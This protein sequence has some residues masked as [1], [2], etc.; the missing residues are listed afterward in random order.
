MDFFRK[1]SDQKYKWGMNMVKYMF[2]I[3]VLFV[4]IHAYA[5]PSNLGLSDDLFGKK[6][7]KDIKVTIEETESTEIRT[8]KSK[9]SQSIDVYLGYMPFS[10]DGTFT[11]NSYPGE[12]VYKAKPA[13][14]GAG[15][16]TFLGKYFCNALEIGAFSG[17]YRDNTNPNIKAVDFTTMFICYQPI[18]RY[19]V[20]KQDPELLSLYAG[21]ILGYSHTTFTY[22]IS[23]SNEEITDTG[24]MIGV[25]AGMK[26]KYVFIEFRAY[27]SPGLEIDDGPREI[28]EGFTA[29]TIGLGCS[30]CF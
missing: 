1:L 28:S 23:G 8:D 10:G 4:A 7:F 9:L 18:L 11:D 21:A 26:V 17:E 3:A 12:T 19:S 29:Y 5:G 22:E 30:M 6:T 15:R 25:L 24:F 20:F 16:Y 14:F 27:P 2:T 13:Y